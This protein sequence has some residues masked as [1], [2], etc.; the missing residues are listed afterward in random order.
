M[1][2]LVTGS[3]EWDDAQ[4]IWTALDA[5]AVGLAEARTPTLTVV[6]GAAK[7][8]DEL[9]DRWVRTH[10]GEL[11]VTA[12]RHPA[13]WQ[14]YGRRAGIFRN[15]L[16]ISKGADLVLAFIRDDSPGATHCAELAADRGFP[17]RVWRYGEP[18]VT[19]MDSRHLADEDVL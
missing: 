17:L 12:E 18:G 11:H 8:A 10:T 14:R 16:M 15:E 19:S 5:V 1:R 9:A 7:G 6:H 4:T 3:R 2:V 13:L